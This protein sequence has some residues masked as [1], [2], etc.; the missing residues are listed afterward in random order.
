MKDTK[1]FSAERDSHQAKVGNSDKAD[2]HNH[3]EKEADIKKQPNLLQT[4]AQPEPDSNAEIKKLEDQ[5]AE[6][7][8]QLMRSRAELENFKKRTERE[9]TQIRNY[10]NER[11][12]V[13]LLAIKDS[14]EMGLQVDIKED[15]KKL[16]EGIELTLKLLQQTFEKFGIKEINPEGEVFNPQ[17]H[18]AMMTQTDATKPSN[19]ILNVLQKGYLMNDRLLRPAMV[20]V[21][22]QPEVSTPLKNPTTEKQSVKTLETTI[23]KTKDES[24]TNS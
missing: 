22:S 2:P 14:L 3:P 8:D 12:A 23:K 16:H 9:I 15:A 21:S 20:C 19:T 6:Y 5:I 10:A 7:Y 18:Q 4:P 24:K 11:F 1:S 17:H 13:E